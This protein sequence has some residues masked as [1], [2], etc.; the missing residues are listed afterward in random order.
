MAFGEAKF[1]VI[2]MPFNPGEA[3]IGRAGLIALVAA[4]KDASFVVKAY[5]DI[6]QAISDQ[7]AISNTDSGAQQG[8]NWL[9][10]LRTAGV[11]QVVLCNLTTGSAGSYVYAWSDTQWSA[12]LTDL[13]GGRF[14]VLCVPFEMEETSI[15]AY[16]SFYN[17][18][19]NRGEPCGL[20]T[21]VTPTIDTDN[22][23]GWAQQWAVSSGNVNGY[24]ALMCGWVTPVNGQELD[25]SLVDIVGRAWTMDM[26]T[27]P[28]M[29]TLEG[30][31]SEATVKAWNINV[32]NDCYDYGLWPLINKDTFNNIMA[33]GNAN[34]PDGYDVRVMRI[35]HGF[36]NELTSRL[37]LG[38]INN[39]NITYPKF[40]SIFNNLRQEYME[41]GYIVDADYT[42]DKSGL[43][44]V[45]L[46]SMIVENEPILNF[47][48]QIDLEEE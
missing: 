9:K 4:Y 13:I 10:K 20:A 7:E 35:Y 48:I 34:T 28:T 17:D 45:T 37:G 23:P 39:V 26:G 3:T 2:Q 33:V 42:I 29:Q 24:G 14:E 38:A 36:I 47:E 11:D 44:S 22:L 40:V 27:S 43:T 41:K 5:N 21:I 18:K 46:K 8:L 12:I 6:D 1:N 31:T 25:A 15:A 30:V 19:F 16:Q 32:L